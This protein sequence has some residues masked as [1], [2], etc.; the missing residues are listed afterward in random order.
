MTKSAT[1][2]RIH[3]PAFF[4][5]KNISCISGDPE[6]DEINYVFVQK[7][8]ANSLCIKTPNTNCFS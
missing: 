4:Q 7:K 8:Q 2:Q 5:T 6:V 3:D 1:S